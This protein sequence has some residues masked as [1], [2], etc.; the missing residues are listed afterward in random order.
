[1]KKAF[2]QKFTGKK[3]TFAQMHCKDIYNLYGNSISLNLKIN[4][5]KLNRK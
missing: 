4:N 5:R 1:M 3:N 2:I